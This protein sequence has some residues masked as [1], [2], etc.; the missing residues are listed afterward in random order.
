[1]KTIDMKFMR[2]L[3]LFDKVTR[4]RTKDCFPY[5]SFIVFAVPKNKISMAI[6]ESGNNV[7]QLNE[8]LGKKVKVVIAPLG[9][10]DAYEF[11]SA[12]VNPI[13]FKNLE[14]T[15]EERITIRKLEADIDRA[16]RDKFSKDN[17]RVTY[18]LSEV[19]QKEC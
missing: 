19:H 9:L 18:T 17:R 13:K 12:I 5:N 15:N 4:V 16:L 6:G 11:I 3:N 2:Y 14:V 10:D 7:K 8:I 1:M